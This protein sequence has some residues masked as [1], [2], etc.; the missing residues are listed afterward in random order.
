MTVWLL[1]APRSESRTGSNASHSPPPQNFVT[2]QHKEAQEGAALFSGTEPGWYKAVGQHTAARGESQP[3]YVERGHDITR[4]SLTLEQNAAVHGQ[5]IDSRAGEGVADAAVTLSAEGGISSQLPPLQARTDS[6]GIFS[7]EAVPGGTAKLRV[8]H[9]KYSPHSEVIPVS[10]SKSSPIKV[11]LSKAM[12]SLSGTV[13]AAGRPLPN[14]LIVAYKAG[15]V[16][17]P[18]ASTVSDASGRYDIGEMDPGAYVVSVEAPVG[19]GDEISGKS[20]SVLL[21]DKPTHLDMSFQHP[22]H[23]SGRVVR[24]LTQPQPTG[25]KTL[26]FSRVEGGS[27]SRVVP[28]GAD[29][30]FETDLE[31]GTYS[32]GLE[33]KP[34]TDIEVPD[35][36]EVELLLEL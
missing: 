29:W 34:G 31:P 33:D 18:V 20:Y 27:A 1:R 22:V 25:N 17:K 13:T 8:E 30:T 15:E 28:L 32:V 12:P 7:L 35:K 14:T 2:V 11:Y 19:T 21:E 10:E 9:P 5:V 26:L 36:S 4:I 23:V 3:V 24:W 16:E 6:D